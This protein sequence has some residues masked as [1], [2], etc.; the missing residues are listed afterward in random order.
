VAT[1]FIALSACATWELIKIG[2]WRFISPLGGWWKPERAATRGGASFLPWQ[3][4]GGKCQ[5]TNN[6]KLSAMHGSAPLL[7]RCFGRA[8]QEVL[9]VTR[10]VLLSDGNLHGCLLLCGDDL[11]C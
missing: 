10:Y 5:I 11:C 3:I 1:F 2:F 9:G 4:E 6:G 7:R 8:S